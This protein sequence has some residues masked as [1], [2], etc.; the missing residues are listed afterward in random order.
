MKKKDMQGVDVEGIYAISFE[1]FQDYLNDFE[2]TYII[3]R[4]EHIDIYLRIELPCGTVK[5]FKKREDIKH[6][7]YKCKCCG[8]YFLK[9]GDKCEAKEQ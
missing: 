7:N 5:D 6:Q 2:K 8:N 4:T 9:F 1:A 3:E